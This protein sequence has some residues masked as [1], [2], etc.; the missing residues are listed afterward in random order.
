MND[1]FL[2]LLNEFP[3]RQNNILDLVITNNLDKI[4]IN[5]ILKPS[6]WEIF[7]H[8]SAIMFE[9]KVAFNP[10]TRTKRFVFD[11]QRANFEHFRV[12]LQTL[13]LEEEIHEFSN[14]D[15][16]WMNWKNAL[17][18][19]VTEFVPVKNAVT[20]FIPVKNAKGRKFLP[21]MNN[22]ILHLTKKKTR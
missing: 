20:E 6:E 12:H 9:L 19:A 17:F 13:N 22:T 11:C 16:D 4:T 10:L 21:W 3:T 2:E 7:T 1:Y 14:I 15:Q 5:E 8:H 18:A